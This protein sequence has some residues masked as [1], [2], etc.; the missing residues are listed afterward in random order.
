MDD[1]YIIFAHFRS[2]YYTLTITIDG[3]GSVTKDPDEPLYAPGTPVELT[4]NPDQGWYFD[5]WSGNLWGSQNPDTIIMNGNRSVIAHFEAEYIAENQTGD[6]QTPFVDISP[7]PSHG[8]V[9]I[10]YGLGQNSEEGSIEIYDITGQL[11]K[12]FSH[13]TSH[14]QSPAHVV[15]D[16]RTNTGIEVPNGVYFVR[17]SA[18]QYQE[19]Q[20]LLFVK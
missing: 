11:V 19:T 3:S 2:L 15:W 1:D 12:D 7:N 16:G 4:A 10:T 9:A 6:I 8:V 14:T 20:K 5:H 13:L 17:F 18:A